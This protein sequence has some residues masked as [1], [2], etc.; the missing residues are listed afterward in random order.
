MASNIPCTIHINPS[1]NQERKFIKLKTFPV[2]ATS[3]QDIQ[4]SVKIWNTPTSF[5]YIVMQTM[6]GI[7]HTDAQSPQQSI[8]SMVP[9]LTGRPKNSQKLP[10]AFQIQK[11]DQ[12]TQEC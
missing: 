3:N 6:Q 5:T 8:Y 7:S 1:C 2:N 10:E 4:K 12:C 9:S 11:Q